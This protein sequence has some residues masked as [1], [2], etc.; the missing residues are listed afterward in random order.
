MGIIAVAVKVPLLSL[1]H[2]SVELI[3]IV[4]FTCITTFSQKTFYY[5]LCNSF[6]PAILEDVL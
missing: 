3:E 4:D 2:F 6:H 1:L 5:Q